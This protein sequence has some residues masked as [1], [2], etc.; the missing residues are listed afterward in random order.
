MASVTITIDIPDG[1]TV[2]VANAD[3]ERR[4]EQRQAAQSDSDDPW[5]GGQAS[6][7]GSAQGS[8]ASGSG[9]PGASSDRPAS[10]TVTDDRGKQWTFAAPNAPSCQCGE[11][12][13]LVKGSTN[14]KPWSQWRCAKSYDDWKSKC[15]FSQFGK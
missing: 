15:Q 2:R 12:A 14:G 8:S 4:H 11:P 3:V 13:A 1:A 7:S 6:T 10:G 5:G 9:S